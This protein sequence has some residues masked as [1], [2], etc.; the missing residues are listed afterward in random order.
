MP[1]PHAPSTHHWLCKRRRKL[2]L[3][4]VSWRVGAALCIGDEMY[5]VCGWGR[6]ENVPHLGTG[7][8]ELWAALGVR[9]LAWKRSVW[10]WRSFG[11]TLGF[12]GR[13]LRGEELS[14]CIGA[15]LQAGEHG[16]TCRLRVPLL[17][18]CCLFSLPVLLPALDLQLRVA[19]HRSK[20]G[21]NSH[22]SLP[23]SR[24]PPPQPGAQ[25]DL[26]VIL[27]DRMLLA[28]YSGASC[29]VGTTANCPLSPGSDGTNLLLIRLESP[30]VS[31]GA[32]WIFDY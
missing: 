30:L 24:L 15:A 11:A 3:V 14:A 5:N 26:E 28:N 20:P 21:G 4:L 2:R 23:G 25:G 7:L 16:V 32:G 13:M 29:F 18:V 12:C 22:L 6:L 1:S 31:S 10:G 19:L 17:L 27:A 8:L 9:S